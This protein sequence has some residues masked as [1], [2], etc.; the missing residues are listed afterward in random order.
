MDEAQQFI[1][2][3]AAKRGY[4][5]PYHKMMAKHDFAV[6]KAANN[7]VNAAYLDKR[8]LDPKVKELLFVTSLASMRATKGHIQAHIRVGLDLG[9]TPQEILEALEIVLPEAGVVAFQ[10][11]FEAWAEV[12]GAEGVEPTIKVH[13]SGEKSA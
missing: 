9:L 1:D 7:L 5:L 4:V 12:V 2:E 10:S 6:L 8:T 13:G 11:A 3:M